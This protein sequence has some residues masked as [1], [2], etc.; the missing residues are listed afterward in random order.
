MIHNAAKSLSGAALYNF[1]P[2]IYEFLV[3]SQSVVPGKLF[4]PSYTNSLA[5]QITDKESLENIANTLLRYVE[6]SNIFQ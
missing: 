4:Q 1:F 3:I 2:V 6:N 5:Q